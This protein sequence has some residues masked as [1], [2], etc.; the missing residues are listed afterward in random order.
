MRLVSIH[1][2]GTAHRI[3]S[4]A[5]STHTFGA[6]W[7][8]PNTSVYDANGRVWSSDFP[9][10]GLFWPNQFY[11]VFLLL[12]SDRTDY[13]ANVIAPPLFGEQVTF[14]DLDLDVI[15]ENGLVQLADIEEFEARKDRYP[16]AWIQQA[17]QAARTLQTLAEASA[18]PFRPALAE[19][20]RAY[21]N[22]HGQLL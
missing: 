1:A 16:V 19:S 22:R 21:V 18:G 11:Q 4:E 13:Y 12:K 2:D 20:W 9:V 17:E 10:V 15:V 7:I 6:Y 14:I 5:I 3:W 8:R